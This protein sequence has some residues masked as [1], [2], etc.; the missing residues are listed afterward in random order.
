MGK[1][2]DFFN[3]MADSLKSTGQDLTTIDVITA[4]GSLSQLIDSESS[5]TPSVKKI[6]DILK[7]LSAET[8][9]G[10]LKGELK[11]VCLTHIDFDQDTVQ[12][13]GEG[14]TSSSDLYLLH[15]K[16]V[17]TAIKTRNEM[18]NFIAAFLT[19]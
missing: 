17:E 5:K 7:D 13:V 16:S 11:I 2:D 4:T 1:I 18:I 6:T 10:P 19:K 15:Q 8:D 3:K 9:G 12:Y 14:V